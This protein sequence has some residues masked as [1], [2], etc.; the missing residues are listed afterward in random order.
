M[1]TRIAAPIRDILIRRNRL[2]ALV[3]LT[4][5]GARQLGHRYGAV[6]R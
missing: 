4:H 3:A 2:V 1:D 6:V 5:I